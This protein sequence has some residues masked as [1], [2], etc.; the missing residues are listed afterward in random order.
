MFKLGCLLLLLFCTTSCISGG[1]DDTTQNDKPPINDDQKQYKENMIDFSGI[2]MTQYLT[3]NDESG[4]NVVNVKINQVSAKALAT[5]ANKDKEKGIYRVNVKLLAGQKNVSADYLKTRDCNF[6]INNNKLSCSIYFNQFTAPEIYTL[7]FSYDGVDQLKQILLYVA[8]RKF[9]FQEASK[10]KVHRKATEYNVSLIFQTDLAADKIS[11]PLS[12]TE[13]LCIIDTTSNG[14]GSHPD[15]SPCLA[16]PICEYDA[17]S[18]TTSRYCFITY[19]V[20]DTITK[21]G[22]NIGVYQPKEDQNL[23][24]KDLQVSPYF[25]KVCAINGIE[26]YN[27][28][29]N[30]NKE[31]LSRL[32]MHSTKTNDPT[33]F[34]VLFC[35]ASQDETVSSNITLTKANTKPMINFE[36]A[37]CVNDAICVKDPIPKSTTVTINN[38]DSKLFSLKYNSSDAAYIKNNLDKFSGMDLLFHSDGSQVVPDKKLQIINPDAI[39]FLKMAE[40]SK[41]IDQEDQFDS[42][43]GDLPL[44]AHQESIKNVYMKGFNIKGGNDNKLYLRQCLH[45]DGINKDYKDCVYDYD[46]MTGGT[47]ETKKSVKSENCQITEDDI[48]TNV[49]ITQF[50]NNTLGAGLETVKVTD[51][52]LSVKISQEDPKP[53]DADIVETD[54]SPVKSIGTEEK[55]FKLIPVVQNVKYHLRIGADKISQL[56]GVALDLKFGYQFNGAEIPTLFSSGIIPVKIKPQPYLFYP[57]DTRIIAVPSVKDETHIDKFF[58]TV[59]PGPSDD[60][61]RGPIAKHKLRLILADKTLVDSSGSVKMKNFKVLHMVGEDD[62]KDEKF[63]VANN[64]GN[65]CTITDTRPDN[66]CWCIFPA[67]DDSKSCN[68]EIK[69]SGV[70][71]DIIKLKYV[72]YVTGNP[73]ALDTTIKAEFKFF[74]K[75]VTFI[76]RDNIFNDDISLSYDASSMTPVQK[77]TTKDE[78]T[79][80]DTKEYPKNIFE[81]NAFFYGDGYYVEHSSNN[82]KYNDRIVITNFPGANSPGDGWWQQV[83]PK[84]TLS[85]KGLSL[86]IKGVISFYR[87]DTHDK[88]KLFKFWRQVENDYD[89]PEIDNYDFFLPANTPV[90]RGG[91]EFSKNQ[92]DNRDWFDDNAWD[93]LKNMNPYNFNGSTYVSYGARGYNHVFFKSIHACYI[94]AR[95]SKGI[96]DNTNNSQDYRLV[97][98]SSNASSI[99]IET[100]REFSQD[101]FNLCGSKLSTDENNFIKKCR[102]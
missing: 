20:R 75:P 71:G 100:E 45:L 13:G 37:I 42:P 98:S 74:Q 54:I 19:T 67:S 26:L 38:G 3:E 48:R 95:Y 72:D 1:S 62:I 7:S 50:T 80:E 93:F 49:C 17:K 70:N 91:A 21:N 81:S 12:V 63:T 39:S 2:P 27:D 34:Q 78:Y 5:N 28:V 92:L 55:C 60:P 97:Q 88:G 73:I 64:S 65:E 90:V 9:E 56:S 87:Y 14:S 94:R 83:L 8:D 44:F 18:D 31:P 6:D 36:S 59:K 15:G 89:R 32:D 10:D 35:N 30:P 77:V 16:A 25:P 61:N 99:C 33:K 23:V 11:I 43:L 52:P 24:I 101:T 84:V 66:G 53:A 85:G 22:Q 76:T 69:G 51:F 29:N 96:T 68:F 82:N 102:D 40:V 86:S 58:V 47:K 57:T 41:D 46:D 4:V 79:G